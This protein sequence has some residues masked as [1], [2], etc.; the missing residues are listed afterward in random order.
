MANEDLKFHK[1]AGPPP[2]TPVGAGKVELHDYAKV[3][4]AVTRKA[5]DEAAARLDRAAGIEPASQDRRGAH[6]PDE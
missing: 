1:P 5:H 2:S 4:G 3:Q 6:K